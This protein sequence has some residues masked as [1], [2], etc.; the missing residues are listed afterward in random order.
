VVHKALAHWDC[1]DFSDKAL[2]R[3]LEAA[4]QRE[5][6]FA[7]ALE[8]AVRQSHWI[9]SQLKNNPIYLEVSQAAR[10]YH[11]LP[12][13]LDMQ[14]RVLH[15]II[16][17]LYQDP[18]GVWHLLDWKAE[19]VPQVGIEAVSDQ[20]LGQMAAYARAVEGMLGPRPKV[21]LCYLVPEIVFQPLPAGKLERGWKQVVNAR[22]EGDRG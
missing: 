18:S 20:H 19:R 22:D 1:L 7:N 21:G 4:A 2:Y 11:E 12:F 10:R 6:V 8:D 17:L 3:W 13:T 5:G 16:D 15:G 9:L 14:G